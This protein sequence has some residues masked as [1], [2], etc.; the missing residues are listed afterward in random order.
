MPPTAESPAKLNFFDQTADSLRTAFEGWGWPGFRTNQVLDWV[1]RK[2]ATDPEKM[3]NLSIHDRQLLSERLVIGWGSISR[4]QVSSDGTIKILLTWPDG[5]NAE[6]VMIPD[7][8]RRTACVSSQVGCPVGCR[9][10]ASGLNGLMGNLAP[11][12]IVE[13]VV[14]LNR[15]IAPAAKES[16]TSYSWEWANPLQIMQ[17][18]YLPCGFCMTPSA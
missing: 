5:K 7:G 13:Q 9:F 11:G 16:A 8:P 2:D 3:T 15:L 12:Q 6:S 18:C 10:C 1:Y 17:M 4:R 14:T